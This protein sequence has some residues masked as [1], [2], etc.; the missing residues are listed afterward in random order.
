MIQPVTAFHPGCGPITAFLMVV[1]DRHLLLFSILDLQLNQPPIKALSATGKLS[2]RDGCGVPAVTLLALGGVEQCK[3]GFIPTAP[4]KDQTWG[5]K[6]KSRPY[7]QT[8][9][10]FIHMKMSIIIETYLGQTDSCFFVCCE[11]LLKKHGIRSRVTRRK[12]ETEVF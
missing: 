3:A 7:C 8:N 9:Q 4:N 2:P 1:N 10:H 5:A 11:D 6:D 12:L